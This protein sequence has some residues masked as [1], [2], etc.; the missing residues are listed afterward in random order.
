MSAEQGDGEKTV[1]Y[2]QYDHGKSA[3]A[4]HLLHV[5]GGCPVGIAT[6]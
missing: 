1:D 6:A 2:Q 4:C 5:A 3:F